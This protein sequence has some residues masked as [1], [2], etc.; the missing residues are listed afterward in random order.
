MPPLVIVPFLLPFSLLNHLLHEPSFASGLEI[1]EAVRP[2]QW[3]PIFQAGTLYFKLQDLARI[4]ESSISA[5]IGPFSQVAG[6][7]I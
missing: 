2:L 6:V 4:S 1:R 3:Y 5:R 7:Q